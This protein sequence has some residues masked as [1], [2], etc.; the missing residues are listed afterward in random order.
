MTHAKRLRPKPMTVAEFLRHLQMVKTQVGEED[1]VIERMD[2]DN[3]TDTEMQEV[4]EEL[5]RALAN[6]GRSKG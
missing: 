1:F 5:P 4:K 3:L 6:N 2:F